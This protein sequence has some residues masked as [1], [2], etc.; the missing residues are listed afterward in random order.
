MAYAYGEGFECWDLGGRRERLHAGLRAGGLFAFVDA[1]RGLRW[2]PAALLVAP[3]HCLRFVAGFLTT[4]SPTA[5]LTSIPWRQ[6]VWVFSAPILSARRCSFNPP[7]STAHSTQ[8][9]S[10]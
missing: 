6:L 4:C 8:C 5:A 2:G 1:T 10:G 3:R 9:S 7:R